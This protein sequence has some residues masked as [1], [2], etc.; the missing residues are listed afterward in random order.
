M[1]AARNPDELVDD[2]ARLGV[3]RG[4]VLMVHASLRALGEV[5][6]RAAGVIAALDRAVGVDGTLL[7]TLGAEDEWSWVNDHP[8]DVRED[9]LRDAEPFDPLTTPAQADI[10]V[11]AEVFRATPGT[12][13]SN[14]PEGRFGAR[15]RLADALTRDVPWDDYYGTGSPLQRVLDEGGRVLRLGADENT[16]TLIHY[17]EYLAHVPEKRRVRRHRR[18]LGANGPEIRVVDCLDDNLGIVDWHGE[19]Y[20]ALILRDYLGSHDVP[21]G[22]VGDADSTLLDARDLVTCAVRWMQ[23]HLAP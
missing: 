4:D 7:M 10:G 23:T 14:H 5:E 12:V 8:E 16:V 18:V 11:L 9:F 21:R 3:R 19:D 1:A 17:A 2:L 20:F 13:V 6:G 15:G 22:R